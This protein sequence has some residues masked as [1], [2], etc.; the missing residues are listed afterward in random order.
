[1]KEL[2]IDTID[3]NSSNNTYIKLKI[4]S[5]LLIK[6]DR[7]A[8]VC[9][10]TDKKDDLSFIT[11][12]NLERTFDRD[13]ISKL[14][15]KGNNI[16]IINPAT[17]H[18]GDDDLFVSDPNNIIHDA[19]LPISVAEIY[20]MKKTLSSLSSSATA[21]PS[22]SSSAS[23]SPSSSSSA[24][25]SPPSSASKKGSFCCSN[26]CRNQGSFLCPKCTKLGLTSSFC[27]QA[28]F[29]ANYEDHKKIHKK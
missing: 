6:G 22:S 11:F 1:M 16:I 27:S 9:A 7:N 23:A 20:Q 28:C 12:S 15:A 26:G 5:N 24:S 17:S 19:V 18:G 14:L 4:A 13:Y 21:S 3:S 2:T 10:I 8:V 29:K 25:A